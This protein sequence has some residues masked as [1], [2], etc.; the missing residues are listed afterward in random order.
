MF[1]QNLGQTIEQEITETLETNYMPYAISVI[2]SRAIPGIDGFKPSHRKLLYTMYTM[3]L[4]NGA[5]TKSANVVGTTM[6]LNPHGDAAIYETM[7]RLTRGN[8]SL[9]YPLVDSKGN[10]G[11]KYSRDMAFA[12]SRYTEVKLE[13]I[14][15]ELFHQIDKNTVDLVDN[16]DGTL[17]EPTLLPVTFPNIL[18]NPNQGI[19]V[20]MTSN[21][22]SYN[23]TEICE[24]TIALLK[25]E[26][27][28]IYE[29]VKGPDFPTG[30]QLIFDEK[31]H[32][33]ILDTGLGSYKLRGK[34]HYDKK[35]SCIDITEIPYTTTIESIIDKIA[36][37]AKTGKLR[38]I[39]EARDESDITGLK[40]SLEI[41]RGT[42]P[43][44]LMSKLLKMTELQTTFSCNFNVLVD[45]SP[46]VL[47]VRDI[48]KQFIR[49]RINCIRRA[50][51][52]E[53]DQKERRLHLLRGLE[54]ILLDID[55]AIAII[56]NTALESDVI[57][58][59]MQ[60][61]DIDQNQAEYIAEIKLRNLNQEYI[62]KRTADIQK[63]LDEISE[64]KKLIESDREI[65]KKIAA[66]QKAIIKKYGKPRKTEIIYEDYAVEY[67]E[68]IFVENYPLKIFFTKENYIK[69]IPLTS[70]RFSGEQ[71]LK[72]GDTIS[73]EWECNNIDEILFFTNHQT[74][75]K[76]HISDLPDCKAS[77]L[78]EFLPNLL[79]MQP[80]ETIVFCVPTKDYHGT[81]LFSFENGKIAKVPLAAYQTK[82]NR[83]QLANAYGA[84]SPL[85]DILYLEDDED[86]LLY[87]NNEKILL[88][89]SSLIPIKTTRSTIGVQV[90]TLR[91]N[92][93][94]TKMKRSEQNQFSDIEYYRGKT[95]PVAGRFLTDEDRGLHQLGL[96]SPDVD[97]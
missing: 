24:A 68:S 57:P 62:L 70:L 75:Y 7:V 47:G 48:L 3:G 80:D 46:Y 89:H 41:K 74:V 78:G 95:I 34:Y 73:Q 19:A 32:R 86:I 64:L 63:L 55:K 67:D 93:V 45:G 90:M 23:L 36:L 81:L 49:F 9:L 40:I 2:V 52:F 21:I 14:A 77:G 33:T 39:N 22:C 53:V 58:N 51:V 15:S 66:E 91:K 94:I 20:G 37:L 84:A 54:K 16:Y 76:A 92:L 1:E 8:E 18:V 83:K 28:D 42:D 65:K 79:K 72:D 11:K 12:A 88:I 4:L 6:K 69:K 13:P 71:K 43:E 26:N 61:F 85:V 60:G 31:E 59:L 56:R 30:G 17:K 87:S 38:E 27:A 44:K 97:A 50:S 35:Q 82:S 10:F 5:R 29:Y 25:N 96:F